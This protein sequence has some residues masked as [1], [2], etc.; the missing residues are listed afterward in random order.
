M[1]KKPISK[2]IRRFWGVADVGE[3][4]VTQLGNVYF[5]YFLTDVVRFPV[6]YVAVI[7]MV[8]SIISIV[9]NPVAGAILTAAKPGKWGKYRTFILLFPP[10]SMLISLFQWTHIGS[11]LTATIVILFVCLANSIIFGMQ[12]ISTFSL[13]DVCA[14]NDEER[15]T[16]ASGRYAGNYLT[17]VVAGY[18]LPWAVAL[19][20]KV[21]GL[22]WAYTA[23][24]FCCGFLMVAGYH[25]HFKLSEGYETQDTEVKVA[26]KE[27]L[28][29]MQL[30][31]ALFTNPPLLSLIIA[32]MTSNVGS[33][34]LPALCVYYYEYVIG[35]PTLMSVHLSVTSLA[36]LAGT[37]VAR[38]IGKK[39]HPR[40]ACLCIYPLIALC[41]FVCRFFPYSAIPFIAVNGLAQFFVGITSPMESTLYMDV[42]VY[43]KWKSGKDSTGFIMGLVSLPVNLAVFV[44]SVVLSALLVSINYVGGMPVTPELQKAFINAYTL[45]PPCI[46]I[47]GFIVMFFGYRLTKDRVDK[48]RAELAEREAA[49]E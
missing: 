26:K 28:T 44:R 24:S 1:E 34:L 32:D 39:M 19:L 3:T 5:V 15:A 4:F 40:T 22:P 8:Q 20:T 6:Q 49:A 16:M 17:R 23:L 21:F 27:K 9:G 12:Y 46:P 2:N 31:K 7:T 48:M 11:D 13:I 10:I 36:G 47:F 38:Y 29:L 25:C 33:F 35:K 18:I 41:W 37:W 43:D 30:L 42:A 45:V 14:S